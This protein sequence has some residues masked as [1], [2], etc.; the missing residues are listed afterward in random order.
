MAKKEKAQKASAGKASKVDEKVI[1]AKSEVADMLTKKK[2]DQLQKAKGRK[3]K[4]GGPA[5]LERVRKSK[6]SRRLTKEVPPTEV[7]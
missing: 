5:L 6:K 1:M 4:S 7:K 2:L 3:R